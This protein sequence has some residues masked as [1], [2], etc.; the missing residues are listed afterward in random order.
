MRLIGKI[1]VATA[2]LAVAGLLYAQ[3]GTVSVSA[4]SATS[5][6]GKANVTGNAK[7]DA[8][9]RPMPPLTPEREAA[10]LTFVQRNHAELA[11]L[12]AALRTNDP[13]QYQRAIRDIY[14]ATDRLAQIQERDPRLYELEVAAWTAQSRVELLAARLKM[15]TSDELIRQLRE[16]LE[17]QND[18]KVALLKHERQKVTDRLSKIDG[19]L[20]RFEKNR[21]ELISKQLKV[22]ER[23]AGEGRAAKTVTKGPFK[24]KKTQT[25]AP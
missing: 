2:T 9:V 15:G 7:K 13:E 14:R 20:T 8:K 4:E 19:D 12:L 21:D 22:L 10:V 5:A 18:A 16:A 17:R 25:A 23:T 6:T 3:S 11:D 24:P 1:M